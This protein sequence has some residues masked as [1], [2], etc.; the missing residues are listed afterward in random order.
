M[1][2]F[3]ITAIK[4]SP[5][6]LSKLKLWTTLPLIFCPALSTTTMERE[7]K[8]FVEDKVKLLWG[9]MW[10]EIWRDNMPSLSWVN[11]ME[12]WINTF[13]MFCV[14]ILDLLCVLSLASEI[15]V[16][17]KN[18]ICISILVSVFVSVFVYKFFVCKYLY[19]ICI[20]FFLS[21]FS[22]V[23][24]YV[25]VTVFVYVFVSAFVSVCEVRLSVRR[26]KVPSPPQWDMRRVRELPL[27]A[28]IDLF[29]LKPKIYLSP[30]NVSQ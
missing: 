6:K 17:S 15:W 7:I 24:V 18:W 19:C 27:G 10:S 22:S 3:Q 25:F 1:L 23:F 4:S 13:T 9:R 12:N 29:C 14:Y 16:E 28:R 30:P 21:A 11:F 5:H 8:T 20:C 26:C 2:V